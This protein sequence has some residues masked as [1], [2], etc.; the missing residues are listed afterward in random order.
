M[1]NQAIA[2]R[3]MRW[4]V[5]ACYAMRWRATARPW[6]CHGM[7]IHATPSHATPR[8]A[9]TCYP[10]PCHGHDMAMPWP[11]H[12]RPGPCHGYAKIPLRPRPPPL[13]D[14]SHGGSKKKKCLLSFRSRGLLGP[15]GAV[16]CGTLRTQKVVPHL[17][18]AEKH[19]KLHD[20]GREAS[21]INIT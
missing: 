7:A 20:M 9:R 21:I 17:W 14:R 16:V 19:Q 13:L 12:G 3:G 5:M 10:I 15:M 6:P 8:H 18:D 2:N 1:A 11:C 4:H